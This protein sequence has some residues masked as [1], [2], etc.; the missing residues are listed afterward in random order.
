VMMDGRAYTATELARAANIAASTASHHLERMEN[1]GVLT[2]I[3]Q[4]RHSYF[5]IAD[6]NVACFIEQSLG[7]YAT[8]NIRTIATSCPR[9]LRKARLC[10]NHLAGELGVR[11]LNAGLERGVFVM[12]SERIAFGDAAV[13][14]RAALALPAAG[15]PYGRFC[16][17]W[18]ERREHLAGDLAADITGAM[19]AKRWLLSGTH[20]QVTLTEKGRQQLRQW[21]GL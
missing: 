12:Q 16:L 19:L 18:S 1:A 20:R 4:G 13:P 6:E 2:R 9:H 17:D 10:Y 21:F 14:F 3:R 15:E 5:R 11:I 8:L 7:V